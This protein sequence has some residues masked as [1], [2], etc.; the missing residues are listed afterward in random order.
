MMKT[1]HLKRWL[2][3][4]L[5]ML[6]PTVVEDR[7]PV[8]KTKQTREKR[9]RQA[10]KAWV[11][12]LLEMALKVPKR[13]QQRRLKMR[14]LLVPQLLLLLVPQLSLLL[15][16]LLLLRSLLL[17]SLLQAMQPLQLPLKLSLKME[18]TPW[19]LFYLRQIVNW[20]WS[21]ETIT[22]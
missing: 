16:L 6:V 19:D 11:R 7:T 2:E 5:L 1:E 18:R 10:T 14:Q 15:L 8:M 4:A 21:M 22:I 13:H 20:I 3:L 9:R 17:R 12:K